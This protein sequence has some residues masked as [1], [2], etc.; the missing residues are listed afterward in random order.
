MDATAL[1]R[2]KQSLDE[3][4]DKQLGYIINSIRKRNILQQ[5]EWTPD[6]I[7]SVIHVFETFFA[8]DDVIK[9]STRVAFMY[10]KDENI[11]E[12]YQEWQIII[13][14]LFDHAVKHDLILTTE[15]D[16]ESEHSLT[17]T[18]IEQSN[19]RKSLVWISNRIKM[20]FDAVNYLRFI[21][22]Q[23]QNILPDV[24]QVNSVFLEFQ[25]DPRTRSKKTSSQYLLE[26]Y[27]Q[28]TYKHRYRRLDGA[29]YKPRFAADGTFLHAYSYFCDIEA[30]VWD[31]IH[32][33]IPSY[34]YYFGLLTQSIQTP[35]FI[36]RTLTN[37]N[38]IFLPKL[39]R[40]D[41]IH[42]FE[43]GVYCL[44]QRKFF[45]FKNT[46]PTIDHL[47]A[48]TTDQII[49]I[50]FHEITAEIVNINYTALTFDFTSPISPVDDPCGITRSIPNISK[51]LKD[52]GFNYIERFFIFGLLGRLL[53][54]VGEYDNWSVF[55]FFIG[56]AGTGKS[57]LLQILAS[58]YDPGDVGYLSN[59]IQKKFGLE[60]IYNKK[61]FLAL[62]IDSKF[63]LDQTSFQSLCSG[64]E[65][66]IQ[67][68]NK[69][70]VSV[71][72]NVPGAF[73]GNTLPAWTDNGGSLSRRLITIEYLKPL[74]AVDTKLKDRCMLE[75]DRFI[76][77]INQ[78]YRH[79]VDKFAHIA[80]KK[81]L[82][83]KFLE[84]Q[85]KAE[86]ALSPVMAFVKDK[87][88]FDE[89]AILTKI[90][91]LRAFKKFCEE[92]S[93]SH[94]T[95]SN[96]TLVNVLSKMRMVLINPVSGDDSNGQTEP[97][98]LNVSFK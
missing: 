49:A 42:A 44:S 77:S 94:T 97:Y 98:I 29:L 95:A 31:A 74:R 63:S 56:L 66:S 15:R 93:L 76:Q 26:W 43:N 53:Y 12:V 47:T 39:R 25:D 88:L 55:L 84:A 57:T 72:W 90:D 58:I 87:C 7:R 60:T 14:Q 46:F 41:D 38:T 79:L 67:R 59:N 22:Y 69:P 68:K 23:D 51:I 19:L 5:Q 73:A 50:R 64:E 92:M 71:K 96:A 85:R 16:P 48:K 21:P 34:S 8:Q 61:L 91:F 83:P 54:R 37:A 86:I 11:V 40:L 32:A 6:M 3:K 45:Y 30:F 13:K 65:V 81:V 75:L 70:A 24:I 52:Q 1:K 35:K 10:P 2:L 82:P 17:N 20:S 80:I 9:L 33:S 27:Y 4:T 18:E 78:C 36:E 28:Q 89:G 62:D